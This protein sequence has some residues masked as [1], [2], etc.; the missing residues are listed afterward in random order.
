VSPSPEKR[1]Q[2]RQKTLEKQPSLQ[3][4]YLLGIPSDPKTGIYV[5]IF[6][7]ASGK[8]L[9]TKK[10]F[11]KAKKHDSFNVSSSQDLRIIDTSNVSSSQC[12]V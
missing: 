11:Y 8:Y 1:N 10:L 3:E 12:W 5:K 9:N 4:E 2:S 7:A 6:D